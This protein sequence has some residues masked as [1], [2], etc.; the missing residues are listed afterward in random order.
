MIYRFFLSFLVFV[1][2][3]L[4]VQ[5]RSCLSYLSLRHGVVHADESSLSWVDPNHSGFYL[6]AD[7]SEN[8]V[9]DFSIRLIKEL[10]GDR[11]EYSGKDLFKFMID[12]FGQEN[13]WAIKARWSEG[14]NLR[15]YIGNRETMGPKKA[16]LET[17][18]GR[19]AKEHGF[20]RVKAY[21]EDED[22][23]LVLSIVRVDVLFVRSLLDV[24]RYQYLFRN[25]N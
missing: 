2:S 5:A 4:S 16:A 23:L 7:L 20:S 8:G 24:N 6:R 22:G 19:R 15:E 9:L 18:T 11:S 13:V 10:N 17:W 3:P 12:H 14:D 1:I 25:L 21:R